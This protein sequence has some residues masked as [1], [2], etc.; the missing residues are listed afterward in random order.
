MNMRK[1]VAQH[2][3]EL[4][5]LEII[6]YIGPGFLVTVGFIDPG[7]WAANVAAGSTYGYSLL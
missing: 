7:N 4:G 6:K 3:P 5:A 2:T 1:S